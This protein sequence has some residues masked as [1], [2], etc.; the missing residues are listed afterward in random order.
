MATIDPK[1]GE[2]VGTVLAVDETTVTVGGGGASYSHPST[3]STA[4]SNCASTITN[5]FTTTNQGIVVNHGT[6]TSTM[7]ASINYPKTPHVY[8]NTSY[9]E[10]C[11]TLPE[12]K[13]ATIPVDD[14]IKYIGERELRDS[15]EV[16]RTLWDRYQTA[17]KLIWS[18]DDE[19]KA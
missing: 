1:L 17:V 3:L 4:N 12:G 11:F 16:V 18:E 9:D 7:W 2:Y 13:V 14:L 8:L 5:V 10:I 6:I 19:Q 15:N